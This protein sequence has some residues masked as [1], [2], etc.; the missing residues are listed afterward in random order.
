MGTRADFYI[1]TDGQLEWQGAIAWDGYCV[2]ESEGDTDSVEK[3]VLLATDPESF[4]TALKA[5]AETRDDWTAPEEGWPW[6]WEDSRT[7]DFAYVHKN[8]K[9]DVY[10]FGRPH[11]IDGEFLVQ[12]EDSDEEVPKWNGFPNMKDRQN[13]Q[14]GKKS[15][16]IIVSA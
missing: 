4:K 16:V 5:F 9:L 14:Y 3:N 8:G 15:G 6:P 13:V 7:T 12:D 1:E 10:I 2:S 11:R